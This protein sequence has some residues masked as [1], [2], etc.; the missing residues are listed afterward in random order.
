[1]SLDFYQDRL[2]PCS[3]LDDKQARNIYPDPLRAMSNKLYGQL[4]QHGFRRSGEHVYR[5]FCPTCS[6]CVPV[7]IK[8][9]D[10][11][12]NRSQK[13]SL[14]RNQHVTINVHPADFNEAH[15]ELYCRY[16]QSR[17]PGGGMDHPTPHSYQ[18]FLTSSWSDTGFVEFFDKD[19][20]IAVAVT[21]FVD[22][23]ASAFYTFFEPEMAE[24]SLGT[25]AVL[26][27]VELAKKQGLQHLYLGY[28]IEASP[29]MNYKTR[30]DALQYFNGDWHD[31]DKKL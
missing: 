8:V 4:I 28:W 21:D 10:F 5:P 31:F 19:Q 2:H 24:R 13:R 15:Y 16:L 14:K 1:M 7:R 30:F 6:A 18:Q 26:K 9:Q 27:Q 29:K 11:Q 12:P 25:L 20:L 22:C 3:Y 17:H 23:A